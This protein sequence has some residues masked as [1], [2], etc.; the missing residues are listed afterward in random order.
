MLWELRHNGLVASFM[1]SAMIFPVPQRQKFV[2]SLQP[3]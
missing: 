1:K 2:D 3:E